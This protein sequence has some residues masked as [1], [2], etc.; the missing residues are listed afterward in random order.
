M[1]SNPGCIGIGL[2]EDTGVLIKNGHQLEVIGSRLVTIVDGRQ[3]QHSNISDLP[4]GSPISIENLTV[5]IMTKGNGF[6][7]Y[8]RK[9]F[10]EAD[11]AV[12]I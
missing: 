7:L 6:D 12:V 1:A 11:Q 4:D 10:K 2:R 5:H 9:F 8:T 3:I